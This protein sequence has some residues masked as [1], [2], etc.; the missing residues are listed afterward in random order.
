MVLHPAGGSIEQL[1][2]IKTLIMSTHALAVLS[3]P[4]CLMGFWGLTKLLGSEK[5]LS[6][7]AFSFSVFGLIAGMCAGT[8]NG[9]V[10]P[11]F[12]QRYAGADAATL[13][14]VRPTLRY[15]TSL[16]HGFDYIFI[17]AMCLSIL[18]WSVEMLHTKKCSKWLAYLGIMICAAAL[19]MLFS[20]FVFVDL[21]GFRVFVFSIV[22]WII[23][24][25]VS[26]IKVKN[27]YN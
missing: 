21:Y 14:S 25:G 17:G 24:A 10:L 13:E 5:F 27:N 23:W 18:M 16:N 11:L 6:F 1:I 3:M 9:F 12:V 2:R 15:A 8:I 7:A 4:F 20:G 19:V 22:T 26:L